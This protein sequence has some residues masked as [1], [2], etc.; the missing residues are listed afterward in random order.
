[1]SSS[2]KFF[3]NEHLSFTIPMIFFVAIVHQCTYNTYRLDDAG[4]EIPNK[5]I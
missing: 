4:P 1:M 3:T 5:G 2:Y